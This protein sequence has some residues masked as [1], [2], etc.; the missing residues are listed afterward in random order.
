V[1]SLDPRVTRLPE[2]SPQIRDETVIHHEQFETYE[3]FVQPKSARPFQHEGSV[4]APNLE[5]AY[6]LAKETFTRRFTCSSIFVIATDNVHISPLTEGDQNVYDLISDSPESEAEKTVYEVFH[7]RK[8]GKQHIQAGQVHSSSVA[9][10]FTNAKNQFDKGTPVFNV[11][12]MLSSDI[13]YTGDGE[14]DFWATLPEKKFRDATEYR[15]GDKLN[16]FLSRNTRS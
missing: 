14:A 10:A 3:V 16:E 2:V 9:A 6:V 13:R 5:L 15:G 1:K 11:W 7:L 12:V 4:H 8:R